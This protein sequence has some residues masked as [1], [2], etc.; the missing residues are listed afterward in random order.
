MKKNTSNANIRKNF[1]MPPVLSSKNLNTIRFNS[2]P[3]TFSRILLK[4]KNLNTEKNLTTKL[5]QFKT[6]NSSNSRTKENNSTGKS[7]I[8]NSKIESSYV[9]NTLKSHVFKPT[10][11]LSTILQAIPKYTARKIQDLKKGYKSNENFDLL[12]NCFLSIFGELDEELGK[13]IK[14]LRKKIGEIFTGYLS[15]SGRFIKLLRNLPDA[16]KKTE[17]CNKVISDTLKSLEGINKFKL[18]SNYQDLYD[19]IYLVAKYFDKNKNPSKDN[20]NRSVSQTLKA[21]KL[22]EESLMDIKDIFGN[23]YIFQTYNLITITM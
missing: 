5:K 14:S 19:F 22:S 12:A 18:S 20:L 4:T 11:E 7:L 23:A 13:E 16:I 8:S 9:L 10:K 3:H 1:D 21:N 15:N 2:T 17:I 6:A